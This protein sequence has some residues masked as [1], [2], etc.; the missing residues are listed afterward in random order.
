MSTKL[1]ART[2]QFGFR[3]FN[4]QGSQQPCPRI[5][6]ELFQVDAGSLFIVCQI[7]DRQ[8]RGH[9]TK[10]RIEGSK[11]AQQR[12]K[13]GSR[14][15]LPLDQAEI[16]AAPSHPN[17]KRCDDTRS[18]WPS[19]HLFPTLFQALDPDLQTTKERCRETRLRTKTARCSPACK[20]T[21]RKRVLGTIM[22]GGDS[23]EPIIHKRGLSHTRPGANGYN[24]GLRVCPRT[25]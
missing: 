21:S 24:V 12:L 7:G 10:P 6:R 19:V 4:A 20:K 18:A 22:L 14:K 25:I 13:E 9:E 16:G 11:S 2:L 1:L 23:S 8:A 5:T 17:L 15:A 3:P